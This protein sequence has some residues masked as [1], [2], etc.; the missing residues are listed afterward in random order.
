MSY[1]SKE[2]MRERQLTS[3]VQAVPAGSK[4]TEVS[5]LFENSRDDTIRQYRLKHI[6]QSGSAH[7]DSSK[8]RAI[9]DNSPRSAKI[10][11]LQKKIHNAPFMEAQRKSTSAGWQ[12][13]PIQL[14]GI[15]VNDDPNLEREA[16]LIGAKAEQLGKKISI[17]Q[18]TPEASPS[19][20]STNLESVDRQTGFPHAL[21]MG[22]AAL[23]HPINPIVHYN[24]SKPAQLNAFAYAQGNDIYLGPD[25]EQHLPHEAFHVVQQ[26]QGRVTATRQLY[27]ISRRDAPIY[28]KAFSGLP[29]Q[30]QDDIVTTTMSDA[31]YAD[32]RQTIQCKMGLHGA[33]SV[34]GKTIVT[35]FKNPAE[36]IQMVGL[37]KKAKAYLV[38]AEGVLTVIAGS[39]AAIISG[40]VGA[41]PGIIAA[42]VGISKIVRGCLMLKEDPSDKIKAVIDALRALEAAA[43]IIGGVIAGNPAIVVFGVA[44]AIRALLMAITDWMGEETKHGTIR[45]ALM[46]LATLAHSVEVVALGF[47]GVGGIAGAEDSAEII[48]GGLVTGVALSK[49]IRTADQGIGAYKAKPGTKESEVEDGRSEWKVS[50]VGPIRTEPVYVSENEDDNSQYYR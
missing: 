10:S 6:V 49:G 34:G 4:R 50:N 45:K 22:F 18:L 39:S 21:K 23:G 33:C 32:W 14:A 29:I 36:V 30:G 17:S 12:D 16:D 42:A 46:A 9:L 28:L 37:S 13:S 44:K 27:S 11:E 3:T 5:Q 31:A 19:K 26:K 2:C 35:Q 24:S 25:Q 41:I 7:T 40:G 15:L 43:A 48:G 8:L 1:V 47:S 38:I 20:G